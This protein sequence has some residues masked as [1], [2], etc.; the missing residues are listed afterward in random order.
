M[1]VAD[2]IALLDM[3]VLSQ[4]KRKSIQIFYKNPAHTDGVLKT[5]VHLSASHL[6]TYPT[7]IRQNV[8][9]PR[10]TFEN[11]P[12][13]PSNIAYSTTTSGF[14]LKSRIENPCKKFLKIHT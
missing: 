11:P 8:Q 9:N 1:C 4:L 2:I 12:L 6:Q 7:P 14:K 3:C 13:C 10:K 5:S